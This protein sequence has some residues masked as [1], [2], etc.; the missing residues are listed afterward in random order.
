MGNQVIYLIDENQLE[1]I[2]TRTIRSFEHRIEERKEHIPDDILTQQQ[3]AE[4]IGVTVATLISYK[5]KR[6]IP[7][8]Q[9][10]RR[11]FFSKR[12]L[13]LAAQRNIH[14]RNA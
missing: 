5:K 11:I 14:L 2:V 8:S 6:L 1:Q 13:L 7:F 12:D 3:A 4:L 9:I 10:G